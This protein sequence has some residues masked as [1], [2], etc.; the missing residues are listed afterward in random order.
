M[1]GAALAPASVPARSLIASAS[2]AWA[3]VH[4]VAAQIGGHGVAAAALRNAS[5]AHS[6]LAM[7][8]EVAA[9]SSNGVSARANM[10]ASSVVTAADVNVPVAVAPSHPSQPS[11]GRQLKPS[12]RK[13]NQDV[14]GIGISPILINP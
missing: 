1:P 8:A 11:H 14:P 6:E 3:I 7:G 10:P 2:S 12:E 4:F 9:P 13:T 5:Y